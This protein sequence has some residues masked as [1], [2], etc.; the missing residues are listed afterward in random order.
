MTGAAWAKW[1]NWAVSLVGATTDDDTAVLVEIR[2]DTVFSI[3]SYLLIFT[4]PLANGI[5]LV[6]ATTDDDT[7][8]LVEVMIR[9]ETVS[10]NS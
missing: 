7:G 2:D 6:G 8:V 5:S 3:S 4:Q 1:N 10:S 9:D